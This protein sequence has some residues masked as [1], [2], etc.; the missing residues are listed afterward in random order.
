MNIQ[1]PTKPVKSN[2]NTLF[3]HSIFHTIQGEGPYSGHAATFVRLLDCNLQCPGCDTEYSRDT[4]ELGEMTVDQI[5]NVV[6]DGIAPN[7]LVI[8][9]GGEPFRQN[10]IPFISNLYED[11]IHVQ[12]E[13]NGVLAPQDN[14][15]WVN[16]L[17]QATIVCSPKTTKLHPK[18][19]PLI[20]YYK[21]VIDYNHINLIDGLPLTALGHKASPHV[22]RPPVNFARGRIYVSPMDMTEHYSDA[23]NNVRN[24][25]CLTL[26]EKRRVDQVIRSREHHNNL[27]IKAVTSSCTQ[28]GYTLQLQLHKLINV[29]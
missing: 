27:N 2:G 9:S 1:K 25:R 22:A 29:E 21:Y 19:I 20:D 5:I 6:N 16:I 7:R 12:I 18:M 17:R 15:G 4:S 11:C 10:L 26:P 14:E 3:V 28:F 23:V 13:T 24:L 8:I